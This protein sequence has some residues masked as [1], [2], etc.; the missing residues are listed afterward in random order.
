MSDLVKYEAGKILGALFVAIGLTIYFEYGLLVSN[1]SYLILV[2]TLVFTLPGFV[3]TKKSDDN[4]RTLVLTQE[5]F[6]RRKILRLV[7]CMPF[8]IL[9]VVAALGYCIWLVLFLNGITGP[10]NLSY[11][12]SHRGFSIFL[13]L[14][15]YVSFVFHLFDFLPPRRKSLSKC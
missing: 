14:I 5:Q 9:T 12:E 7:N 1:S 8:P 2:L 13:C 15:F 10:M 11:L 3:L 6:R 4:L